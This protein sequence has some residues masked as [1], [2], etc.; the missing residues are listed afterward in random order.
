[1][2]PS[3]AHS[4]GSIRRITLRSW[5]TIFVSCGLPVVL[6]RDEER[7]LPGVAVRRLDHEVGPEAGGGREV[8]HLPVGRRPGPSCW[9]RSARPPRSPSRVVSILESSRWRSVAGRE[10]HLEPE[11]AGE[12]LGLLVEHQERDLAARAP[13]AD[14]VHDLLVPQQ[15]VADLL[16]RL[17]RA[18]G[19]LLRHE[20]VR[21]PAVE[22]VV[23]VHEPEVA[24]PPVD[25]EQVERGGGRRS[26]R[27]SRS[28]GR[29]C[30][31]PGSRRAGSSPCRRRAAVDRRAVGRRRPG[32]GVAGAADAVAFRRTYQRATT[33]STTRAASHGRYLDRPHQSRMNRPSDLRR[34]DHGRKVHPFP[35]AVRGLGVRPEAHGRDAGRRCR[36][37]RRRWC[38]WWRRGPGRRRPAA[39][40]TRPASSRARGRRRCS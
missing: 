24:H 39:R 17:E 25:A 30:G 19:L 29:S 16:D 7:G 37:R 6:V 31:S 32:V 3:I 35:Y 36:T 28:C 8:E 27:A 14:E 5:P 34:L 38:R 11:F 12:R 40:T 1:M 26:R 9:A 13:A 15:V 23:V 20:H 18:R 33:I 10:R 2:T 21:M 4:R 22:R